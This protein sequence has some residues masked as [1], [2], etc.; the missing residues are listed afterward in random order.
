MNTK[1]A[2]KVYYALS[3]EYPDAKPALVYHSEYELLV[4]V[5]L[6]AQCT[7][8]ASATDPYM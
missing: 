5:I 4:C 1:D 2:L 6:S 8:T 7:D 3:E